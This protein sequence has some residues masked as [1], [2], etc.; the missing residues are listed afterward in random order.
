MDDPEARDKATTYRKNNQQQA[1]V[2]PADQSL[3]LK[4]KPVA[5]ITH[6]LKR[7]QQVHSFKCVPVAVLQ[8]TK[9]ELR[10][11]SAGSYSRTS[12]WM[13]QTQEI[14]RRRTGRTISSKLQCNQ[15]WSQRRSTLLKLAADGF[16]ISRVAR[17]VD[18]YDDVGVTY[19]LLLVVVC[20]AM[21]AA[22]QQARKYEC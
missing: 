22:D 19:S 16:G 20:V 6:M 3:S 1:T 2:Q 5:G 7:N 4:K 11:Q 12:R 18:R 17:A 9:E 8:T 14:K 21:V 15:Q 13:T 10:Q